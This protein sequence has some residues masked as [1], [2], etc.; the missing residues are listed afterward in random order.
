MR[1]YED[2]FAWSCRDMPGLDTTIVE[3]KLPLIP[4]AILVRQHLR[5]MKPEVA[6][7]IKEKVENGGIPPMGSQ[8]HANPQEGWESA[9]V[10]DYRDLN[11]ASL[12][13]NFPLP[14]IDL[15]VDNTAQHSYYSFMDGFSR[16]NE[17]RMA[18]EDKEKTTFIT[19]WGTFCYKVMPFGLKNAEA[20]YQR[21]MIILFH[22][23]MHKE[24]EFYVDDMIAK[25]KTP[26]QHIEDLWK[27]FERLRKYRL[28][29]NPAKCIFW[30]RNGELTAT[31]NLI[32]KLLRKNQKVEWN[33]ECQEAF[34]KV[35]QCLES[36]LVLVPTVP[37]KPLILYLTMLKE[38][39]GGIL[40]QQNDSEKEQAI[41]YHTI[42]G[43]ALGEHLAYHPLDEYHPFLH[44][45]LDEHIIA[46]E[47][48]E[49]EIHLGKWKLWFDGAS[50]LL[51]NGIGAVLASPKGQYF[52]FS[53]RLGFDCTNNV[54]EY[55]ACT[56]G[57]TMAIEHQVFGDSA[58]V[59]YQ[60]HGEW[61]T[62]DAKLVPY[63]AHIMALKEHF[64]EISFHYVPRDEN[65]MVDALATLSAMLQANW[66]KEMTIHVRQQTKIAHCQQVGEAEIDG[67]PWYHDI[68]EYLKKCVY[69]P[70]ATKNDK[71]TLK[72]LAAG[73]LLIGAILYKRS[74]D[75]T[76][77]HCVDDKEAQEIME[78]VHGGAFGTHANGHALTRKILRAGYYWSK[79]E[80]DCYRH[81]RR[82]VKCQVYADNIHVAPSAL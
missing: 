17:L 58:L 35:K 62:R 15:L 77:L 10:R 32:F 20:T 14:H 8:H 3:H 80:S 18:P 68:R 61:E 36:P 34:E 70:E 26:R 4:N 51:G 30:R 53:A 75:S 1:E 78:E 82:C 37:D 65:Q 81:M 13:D 76:L 56:M 66:G 59:I 72:R 7:K 25:S 9:N 71:R 74:I 23:M 16:Y 52:P 28:R 6:L 44:E 19:T 21:V 50:N 55:E 41:Y 57:I 5:R 22:N 31:C 64:E 11:R 45:F 24:V 39:M 48:D 29:L 43:S 27:L 73:F 33:P 79:M 38:S 46:A 54:V 60:L 42:K 47:K 12:K 49:Q 63:H 67:Q 40:G 2:I 69:P